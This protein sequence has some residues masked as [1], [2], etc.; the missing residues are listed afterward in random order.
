MVKNRGLTNTDSYGDIMGIAWR[1]QLAP[2]LVYSWEKH[3]TVTGVIFQQAM[4][5]MTP[6]GKI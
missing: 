6:E 4:W 1:V 3:R 5:L 2:W